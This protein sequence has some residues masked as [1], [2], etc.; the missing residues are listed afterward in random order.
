MSLGVVVGTERSGRHL[1]RTED[2]LP[3]S[4]VGRFG[5]DGGVGGR[6]CVE[7]GE[8]KTELVG[9]VCS[10]LLHTLETV[11]FQGPCPSW[12]R[13]TVSLSSSIRTESFRFI[14]RSI[15]L[16]TFSSTFCR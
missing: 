11:S 6:D 13:R 10:G 16:S 3:R 14:F 8:K 2:L 4:L 15:S 1:P 12:S 5:K 7:R 9:E